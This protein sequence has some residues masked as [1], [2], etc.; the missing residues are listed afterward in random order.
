MRMLACDAMDSVLKKKTP[1]KKHFHVA[2]TNDADVRGRVR[3]SQGAFAR[4][5]SVA[6]GLGRR[7]K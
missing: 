4:A 2:R 7:R 6:G 1:E 3:A 5:T